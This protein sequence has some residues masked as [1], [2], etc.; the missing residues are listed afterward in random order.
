MQIEETF[1]DTK[2][3]RFG[4]S[5]AEARTKIAP[6]GDILMLLASLAHLLT[7]L[8]G[9]VAE[10]SRLGRLYQANTLRS[11]RVFSLS[12]LGRLVLAGDARCIGPTTL[13]AAW[14]ALRA[15]L[16]PLSEPP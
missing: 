14:A 2:S 9:L 16:L 13:T 1:R 4:L 11:R 7:I 15:R 8:A 3:A 12:R 5:M 6:R 10:A